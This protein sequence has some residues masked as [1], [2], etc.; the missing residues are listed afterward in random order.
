MDNLEIINLWKQYDEKLEKTLSI[1]H[2]L[3]NELQQQK[4]KTVL[5]PAKRI[6][7]FGVSIGVV[8]V[9]FLSFF[10]YHSLSLEK[11]FFTGSLI[12]IMVFTT[13]AIIAY[14]YQIKL[15]NDIDN[16]D[17]V[18]QIQQ[19]LSRLQ[20]STLR[21]TGILFL[22]TPFYATWFISFNWIKESPASFYFIQLPIVAL[23]SWAGIW[24]FRNIN[25]KNLDKKW[26]KFLIGDKEWTS[27]VK[28]VEFLKEI[29]NFEAESQAK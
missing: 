14:I 13:I 27:T 20:A 23:L 18:I 3:I 29:E 12:A 5:R 16:S 17:T 11:I 2:K 1:N 24:L 8:F 25:S 19:K 9:L 21:I 4:V 7:L 22:Q 10:V 15:I 28:S 26:F 6:K